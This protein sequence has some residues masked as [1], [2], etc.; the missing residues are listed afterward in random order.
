MVLLMGMAIYARSGNC[1]R[2][3]REAH[4]TSRYM[5]TLTYFLWIS[6]CLFPYPLPMG[7]TKDVYT[8]HLR[9]LGVI[10][11]FTLK[12]CCGQR[13]LTAESHVALS[14]RA[15]SAGESVAS[16][17]VS[18]SGS[19]GRETVMFHPRRDLVH[20][21]ATAGRLLSSPLLERRGKKNQSNNCSSAILSTHLTWLLIDHISL[22][23]M[24][25]LGSVSSF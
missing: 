24:A 7:V 25:S 6:G 14:R 4:S 20:V 1:V 17:D 11:G 18:P 23:I 13:L 12:R 22:I 15:S 3:L 19:V 8:E 21:E 2:Q 9:V 5:F 16:A 10:A